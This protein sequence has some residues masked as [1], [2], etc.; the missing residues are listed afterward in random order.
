[1]TYLNILEQTNIIRP[2]KK[3]SKQISKKPDKLLFD[4]TNLLYTYADELVKEIDIGTVRETFFVS[5]FKDI[6][7]SDI[8]DFRVGD[9]IF[10]IGGKNKKFK[11]IKD[12]KNSYLVIDTDYTTQKIKYL[13]GYLDFY[14]KIDIRLS[15]RV[16]KIS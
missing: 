14:I 13:Y 6:Y 12:V 7:Y 9:M 8:G 4:N 1:M 16:V 15:N 3:Y 2:V 10:E 11:Q 5:C